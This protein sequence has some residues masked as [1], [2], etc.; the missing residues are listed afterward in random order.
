VYVVD[1]PRAAGVAL[2]TARAGAES[3]H[4]L[5]RHADET[6]PDFMRRV[7]ARMARLQR[8]RRVRA[9]WYVV[10]SDAAARRSAPL[11]AS[12][13]KLLSAGASLTVVGPG[14]HQSALFGWIETVMQGGR[15][16]VVVRA[17][18]YTE[19]A[20]AP[21]PSRAPLPARPWQALPAPLA[22]LMAARPALVPEAVPAHAA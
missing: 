6:T 21:R 4:V 18:L 19:A 17:Q 9:L 3:T 7:L 16:D 10:G 13:S 22:G 15:H 8:H 1:A 12:L 20:D 11:L 14:S 2:G 5:C